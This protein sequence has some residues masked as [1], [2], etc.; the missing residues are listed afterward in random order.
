MSKK[1]QPKTL[2]EQ[3]HAALAGAL[4]SIRRQA[5]MIGNLLRRA[6]GLHSAPEQTANAL[7]VRSI[8]LQDAMGNLMQSEHP[9]G[10]WTVYHPD[11]PG[12]PELNPIDELRHDIAEVKRL[13]G[14]LT[15]GTED[16]TARARFEV[17]LRCLDDLE[18]EAVE[19]A[20][21]N[22]MLPNKNRPRSAHH[23]RS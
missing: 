19:F 16:W 7:Y 22:G 11:S 15:C 5:A 2:S 18:E 21:C 3:Q 9:H 10:D 14:S 4:E 20:R 8:N 1:H 23:A 12:L 6:Y 13:V 17:E